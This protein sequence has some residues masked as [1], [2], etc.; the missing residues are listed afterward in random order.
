LESQ[1]RYL[2]PPFSLLDHFIRG[3]RLDLNHR[4]YG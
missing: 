1:L 4:S 3:V 2:R